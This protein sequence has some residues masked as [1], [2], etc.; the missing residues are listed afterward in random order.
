MK[1]TTYTSRPLMRRRLAVGACLVAC[2][3]GSAV[4]AQTT[5]PSRPVRL[6]VGFPQARAPTSWPEF[7][8][9]SCLM[10]GAIWA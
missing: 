3:W 7:W 2:V 5:Y 6:I 8:R 4:Q 1:K 9:K 10:H